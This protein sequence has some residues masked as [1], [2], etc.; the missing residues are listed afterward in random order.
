MLR[1][2]SSLI[3]LA[4]SAIFSLCK[5]RCSACTRSGSHHLCAWTTAQVLDEQCCEAESQLHQMTHH[6]VLGRLPGEL[7][8]GLSPDAPDELP[9]EAL[10]LLGGLA[11]LV[12]GLPVLLPGS[13][14]GV[15]P[16]LERRVVLHIGVSEALLLLAVGACRGCSGAHLHLS[17][18]QPALYHIGRDLVA[19]RCLSRR[20]HALQASIVVIGRPGA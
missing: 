3:V 13:P 18:C 2:F 6:D 17:S 9:P 20:Q 14:S 7:L 4:S 10:Q 11:A 16:L 1:E 19:P 8:P 5:C 12:L 15:L